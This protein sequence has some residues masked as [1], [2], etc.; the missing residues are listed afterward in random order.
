MVLF[1]TLF[2]T[3]SIWTLLQNKGAFANIILRYWNVLNLKEAP[4][5]VIV[6]E[7]CVNLALLSLRTTYLI[8]S[9]LQVFRLMQWRKRVFH[10]CVVSEQEMKNLRLLRKI[11]KN[12]LVATETPIQF[13]CCDDLS[14]R[15]FSCKNA[16]LPIN[17]LLSLF[18]C[19][20]ICKHYVRNATDNYIQ[21]FFCIVYKWR[22]FSFSCVNKLRVRPNNGVVTTKIIRINDEFD[23]K[24]SRSAKAENTSPGFVFV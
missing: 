13:K 21:S 22:F 12:Q 14:N 4:R 8:T 16:Q 17:Y 24:V 9:F 18:Q 19:V 10:W 7:I 23:T 6:E 3:T 20:L 11:V 1:L 5:R 2:H 15:A